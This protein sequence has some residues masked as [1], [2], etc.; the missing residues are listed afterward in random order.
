M[1]E[2]SGGG[3]VKG[4]RPAEKGQLATSVV[5]RQSRHLRLQSSTSEL[6]VVRATAPM[7]WLPTVTVPL[8]CV[9]ESFAVPVNCC[10]GGVLGREHSHQVLV[11]R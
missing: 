8:Y 11:R 10:V 4:P 6:H 1:Y 9:K 2:T 7:R 3:T 5:M